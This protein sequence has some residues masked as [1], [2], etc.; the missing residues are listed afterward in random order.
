VP[1]WG[2]WQ[3]PFATAAIVAV[4]GILLVAVG[5]ASRLG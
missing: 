4:A 1:L 5:R 2:S 3:A